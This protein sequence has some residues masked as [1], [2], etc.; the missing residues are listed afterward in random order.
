VAPG[1][2]RSSALTAGRA[3]RGLVRISGC[4][5]AAVAGV[6]PGCRRRGQRL[7]SLDHGRF[8]RVFVVSIGEAC[9]EA[10]TAPTSGGAWWR[11]PASG[12]KSKARQHTGCRSGGPWLG[13]GVGWLASRG[14]RSLIRAG[15]ARS[16]AVRPG[17]RPLDRCSQPR[18]DDS[19]SVE[20][21]RV[22][23]AGKRARATARQRTGCRSGGPWPGQDLGVLDQPRSDDGARVEQCLVAI[24]GKWCQGD[25]E[26]AHRLP[27]GRAVAWSRSRGARS[28]A[29]LPGLRP[30]DW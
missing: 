25:G 19:A 18:G 5:Q 15:G 10:T 9:H 26:A 7:A 27:I 11:S 13:Q 16:P 1:R 3:C 17:L 6:C 24:A 21:Y 8:V 4:R 12:A 28:P 22:A 14:C 23:I 30:L 2:R 29:V 20:Q